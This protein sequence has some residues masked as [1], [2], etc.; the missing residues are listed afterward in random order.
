MFPVGNPYPQKKVLT[1]NKHTEDFTFFVNYG[2]MSTLPEN[3]VSLIGSSNITKVNLVGIGE[4]LAKHKDDG[5]EFKGIKAHFAI[6]DSGLLLLNTVEAIFEKIHPVESESEATNSS[7][8]TQM[9]KYSIA[10]F[11]MKSF[12]FSSTG[13]STNSTD[14][15]NS[16]DATNSATKS[17]KKPKVETLKEEVA[18]EESALDLTDLIGDSLKTAKNRY[19]LLYFPQGLFRMFQHFRFLFRR[20]EELNEK[21]RVRKER[22]VARNSLE[23]FILDIQDKLSQEEY[24]QLTT[25]E[26]R[27]NVLE[28][29]SQV[30]I[31]LL[32]KN[33][34]LVQRC[35]KN[36]F[37]TGCMTR[38]AIWMPRH[39]A[40]NFRNLRTLPAVCM[41][42]IV[43]SKAARK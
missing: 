26:E 33:N 32:T 35:F 34:N 36:R 37:L 11:L 27:T 2:N 24:E 30:E 16:S 9:P 29:C 10:F 1:F 41:K 22:E 19:N 12:H 31:T 3:E 38:V 4:A 20:I 7:E 13:S 14:A 6:D 18:K 21:E 17:E 39:I 8:G 25:E 40:R 5:A 23:T 15:S 28:Q 43:N 42:D